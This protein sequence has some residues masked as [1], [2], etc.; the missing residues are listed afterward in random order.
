MNQFYYFQT[1]DNISVNCIG[2]LNE[3]WY[4]IIVIKKLNLNG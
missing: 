3:S 2:Y 4:K 1:F